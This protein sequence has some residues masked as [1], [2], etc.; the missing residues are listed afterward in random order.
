M[1]AVKRAPLIASSAFQR[2]V[3]VMSARSKFSLD[4]I[5]IDRLLQYCMGTIE[6]L[7]NFNMNGNENVRKG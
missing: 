7:L 6:N 3:A 5:N 1:R 2:Y 4:N